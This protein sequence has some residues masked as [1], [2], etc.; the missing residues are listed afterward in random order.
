MSI[1]R[2]RLLQ[3]G[4]ESSQRGPAPLAQGAAAGVGLSLDEQAPPVLLAGLGCG[5]DAQRPIGSAASVLVAD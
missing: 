2:R 1:L 5:D 4:L 3:R